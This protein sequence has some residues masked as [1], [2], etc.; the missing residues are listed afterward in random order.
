[1]GINRSGQVRIRSG[2]IITFL[3]TDRSVAPGRPEPPGFLLR[4]LKKVIALIDGFN[5]YHS[6]NKREFK[7]VDND[8][9]PVFVKPYH[10]YKWL[11]LRKLCSCFVT[12]Q[13][14]LCEVYYF[15]ALTTWS[16]EKVE[17][18]K[19]SIRALEST[20]VT[21]VYGAFKERD[22]HCIN[23]RTTF[24]KSEEKRT[25][26]NIAIH[27]LGLAQSN[28]YDRALLLSGDSDLI[29]AISWTRAAFP[30]KRISVIVPI[31]RPLTKHLRQVANDSSKIKEHH[32][33][34]C[35]LP[36]TIELKTGG[37]IASPYFLSEK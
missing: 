14:E 5:V 34:D 27:L 12:L 1:M 31:A 25:D 33:R 7:R 21:T 24:T 13:E 29:P 23:C 22:V 15:T 2:T 20:G 37:I 9:N 26:V 3:P 16:E 36:P 32:L 10:Q 35:Q 11:D 18:H 8:G 6:L 4:L 28:T 30:N 19:R 17:R